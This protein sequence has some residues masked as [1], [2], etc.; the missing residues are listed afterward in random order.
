MFLDSLFFDSSSEKTKSL[1]Q[2]AID[3][4]KKYKVDITKQGVDQRYTVGAIKYVQ[5]LI[6][7]LL[8]HQISHSIDLGWF[9][10]FER[11]LIKD[12]TKFDVSE[13]LAKQLPGFGGNAS[14]AGVSIQY[15]FDIKSGEVNDLSITPANRPDTRDTSET[16]HKVRKGDLIIRDLGYSI[17]SCFISIEK[18][19]AYFLSRLNGNILVYERL[20]NKLVELDFGKL[21][22]L[23]TE[24]KIQRLDKQVLIGKDD[25]FPVRLIIELMPEAIV[26]KRLGKVNAYNKKNGFET[27]NNY[28]DRAHFNLFITN[29][30]NKVM[31]A[32]EIVKIY[33]MRWQVELIF[34]GWKSVFGIDNNNPMKHER[35]ICL[36]NV[37]LLLILINWD[38]FMQKRSQLYKKT[39]RLLSVNKCFKTS[40]ENS[41]E[42]SQILMNNCKKLKSW[43]RTMSNLFE[44]HH[45]L[46]KKKN[47]IGLAD[48][49]L[50]NIL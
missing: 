24:G 21:Y 3:T 20:E 6:G 45:W 46:E 49:L 29:I 5:S 36:L 37:R 41:L 33:K 15:E 25:K 1:N 38:L 12:S 34:K 18:A 31:E 22:R 32:E 13:N 4:K 44:T 43:I 42:L 23:M 30:T 2:L 10:L 27:S 35:L 39:G 16:I 28:K 48:L 17:L 26:S 19:K 8:S 47:K 50:L 7:E 14:K 11:V 9:K 40:Q